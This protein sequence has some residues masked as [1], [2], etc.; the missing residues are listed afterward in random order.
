MLESLNPP[1]IW[2]EVGMGES[3]HLCAWGLSAAFRDQLGHSFV[4]ATSLTAPLKDRQAKEEAKAADGCDPFKLTGPL[5]G[6]GE[7]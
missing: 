2:K 1:G 3:Q 7:V 6:R 5:V 4:T